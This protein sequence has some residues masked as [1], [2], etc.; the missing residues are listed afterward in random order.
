MPSVKS[1]QNRKRDIAYLNS[2]LAEAEYQLRKLEQEFRVSTA[3][4]DANTQYLLNLIHDY[5]ALSIN[6]APIIMQNTGKQEIELLKKEVEALKLT[7]RLY[8]EYILKNY[9]PDVADILEIPACLKPL[10]SIE[11]IG[12]IRGFN[13][14]SS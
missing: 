13:N 7:N 3:R 4:G 12:E 6:P 1:Y 11:Y 2:K 9:N 5:T 14:I 10:D 8:R